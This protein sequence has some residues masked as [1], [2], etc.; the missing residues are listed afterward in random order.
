MRC[1]SE[2]SR[3]SVEVD[4]EREVCRRSSLKY[5][6]CYSSNFEVNALSLYH[7]ELGLLLVKTIIID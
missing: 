7:S 4:E 5:T 6:V 1:R 3:R 2:S